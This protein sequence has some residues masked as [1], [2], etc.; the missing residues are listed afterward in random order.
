MELNPQHGG[1]GWG[2]K[3]LERKYAH[4]KKYSI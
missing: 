1:G 2:C 4:T 3:I